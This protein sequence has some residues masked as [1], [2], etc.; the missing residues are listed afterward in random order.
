M[1]GL[2]ETGGRAWV[3]KPT[4]AAV[5]KFFRPQKWNTMTVS[6]HGRR[7]VVKVNGTQTAELKNDRGRLKGHLALPLHGGQ[8]VDVTFKDMEILSEAKK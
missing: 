5:K 4:P 2:Y 3:V 6:A 1:G 7:I 8:D